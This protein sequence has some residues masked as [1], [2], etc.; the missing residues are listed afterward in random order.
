MIE[1]LQNMLIF[2][3]N[4]DY[5][6]IFIYIFI[7]YM[8]IIGW[9]RGS[10]LIAFY[11]FSFLVAVFLSFKY[12]FSIG[13]YISSWLSSNRQISQI[14]A[15]VIIFI[16]VLTGSSLINSFISSKQSVFEFYF[17][18]LHSSDNKNSFSWSSST[19]SNPGFMEIPSGEAL[20]D[21]VTR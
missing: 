5:L 2:L 20:K 7:I 3:N 17:L 13:I 14:F 10:L 16:A 8:L 4:Q 9:K 18:I 12:S 6:D 15:G 11:I 1:R 21:G 19:G